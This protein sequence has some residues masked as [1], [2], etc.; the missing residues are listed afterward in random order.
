MTK[1]KDNLRAV[2]AAASAQVQP[3]LQTFQDSLTALGNAISNAG[4]GG[5]APVATA[6][7]SAV[8]SGQAVITALG[9]F[10]C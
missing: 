2:R 9:S 10:K 4:S 1:I 3:Q 7:A 8:R 6:A 5:F